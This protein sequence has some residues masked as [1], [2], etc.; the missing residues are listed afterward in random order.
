MRSYELMAV[1]RPDLE[2]EGT[3]K[4]VERLVDLVTALNGQVASVNHE[5]PWG[6]RRL[7]YS[8]KH[9]CDGYYVLVNFLMDPARQPELDRELKLREEVLRY[10]IVRTGT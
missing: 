3:A 5:S 1:L 7:A 10:L 2:A 4:A 9:Y 6:M 8:I